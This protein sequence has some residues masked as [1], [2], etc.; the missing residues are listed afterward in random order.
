MADDPIEQ[1]NLKERHPEIYD[2]IVAEWA[3][4]NA[5]ML[6]ETDGSY[7]IS[8]TGDQLADHIG[9]PKATGKADNPAKIP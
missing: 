2:R 8:F 4:C 1:A 6:P 9:A 3:T 5:A 7:T